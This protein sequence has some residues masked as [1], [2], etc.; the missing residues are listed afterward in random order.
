MGAGHRAEL[1]QLWAISPDPAA[2]R[3]AADTAERLLAADPVGNGRYLSEELWKIEISPLAIYYTIDP[4]RQH[5][6]ITDVLEI[7]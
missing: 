7:A 4:S 2:V 6:Q 1:H 3:T 5:V